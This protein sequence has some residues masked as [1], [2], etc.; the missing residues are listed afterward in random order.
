MRRHRLTA[1]AAPGPAPLSRW[2]GMLSLAA[3]GGGSGAPNNPNVRHR[4]RR[5]PLLACCRRRISRLFG[6]A[7]DVDDHRRRAALPRVSRATCGV[8]PVAAR[9]LAAT[10]SCCSANPVSADTDRDAHGPG[11]GRPDRARRRSTV[12][13][14]AA[15]ARVDHDHRQSDLRALRMRRH[16]LGPGRNGDGRTSPA[17]AARR[18]PGRQ[19]RF[20]VVL[21]HVL[22][23]QPP[24]RRRRWCRR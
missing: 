17:S 4:R 21:R 14:C 12:K 11:C 15:A 9:R 22:D 16:L 23:R 10:R 6:H 8:L 2:P 13:P 24:I 3:C 20:D 19:V 5:R 1:L 7:G 18:S